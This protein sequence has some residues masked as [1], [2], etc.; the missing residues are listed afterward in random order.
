MQKTFPRRTI[1]LMV[2]AVLA[3]ARFYWVTHSDRGAPSLPEVH[4]VSADA[5][6]E[7]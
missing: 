3:F 2:L 5:G 4:L 1:L 6:G 7:R